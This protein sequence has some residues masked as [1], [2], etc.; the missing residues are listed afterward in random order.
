MEI[1][2]AKFIET[3]KKECAKAQENNKI[4]SFRA[5]GS[6]EEP[7]AEI[8]SNKD[9]SFF[10]IKFSNNDEKNT[11]RFEGKIIFGG[12]VDYKSID[13]TEEEFD[14]LYDYFSKC[15][16]VMRRDIK[17]DIILKGEVVL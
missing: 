2:K 10:I 1:A 9:V 12:F 16:A 13:L 6:I 7:S 3:F 15:E 5:S 14:S 8:V 11:F 17:N 4:E